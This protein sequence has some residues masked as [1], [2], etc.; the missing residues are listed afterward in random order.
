MNTLATTRKIKAFHVDGIAADVEAVI[1]QR[2]EL[3]SRIVDDMR[4]KG[5]VPVLDITP[6]MFTHYQH[7]EV[8]QNFKFAIIVYGV[9]VGKRKSRK[10]MGMLGP[11]QILFE[12]PPDETE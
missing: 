8:E 6:E 12:S 10:I 3:E 4:E 5:Y 7:E 9:F 11:H 1:R 2:S